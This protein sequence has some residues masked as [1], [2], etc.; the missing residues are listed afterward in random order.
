MRTVL[1]LKSLWR[2]S[3]FYY[4]YYQLPQVSGM[5]EVPRSALCSHKVAVL[6]FQM[7]SIFSAKEY[8]QVC[9]DFERQ[10]PKKWIVSINQT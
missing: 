6:C 5:A 7:R 9:C 4:F 10:V 2:H 3:V 8:L 1:L